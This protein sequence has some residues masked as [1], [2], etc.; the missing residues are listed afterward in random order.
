M[1]GIGV[2]DIQRCFRYSSV[3]L[4]RENAED[5]QTRVSLVRPTSKKVTNFV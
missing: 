3:L 5:L 2:L 1:S 4:V